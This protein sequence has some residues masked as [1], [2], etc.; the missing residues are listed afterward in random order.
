MAKTDKDGLYRSTGSL[1]LRIL[2]GYVAEP[3]KEDP[4]IDL[5]ERAMETFTQATV[6]GAF[7]VDTI[8]LR[9]FT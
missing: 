2:Y 9:E 7:L 8:P 5:V 3:V 4:L 6:P 1:A